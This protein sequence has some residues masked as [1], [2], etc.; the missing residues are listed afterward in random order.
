[1]AERLRKKLQ[2]KCREK[3]LNTK[4]EI[5]NRVKSARHQLNSDDRGG[6]EAD[7]TVRNLAE[8]EML[9]MHERLRSQLVEIEM[10]LSRIDQGNYGIC[11]ETEEVIE[12]DRLLA[13]P[14][15]RL[16][17]EGAELRDSMRRKYA[18]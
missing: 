6:D 12:A 5:I 3:L 10:A 4:E 7:Q 17:I 2:E 9:A 11:E 15:T 1:M 8:S 18:R 14:W 13:I 16:S